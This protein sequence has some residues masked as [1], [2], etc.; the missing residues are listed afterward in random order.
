MVQ[1][2]GLIGFVWGLG[3]PDERKIGFVLGLIGFVFIVIVHSYLFVV[4]CFN[5]SCV[6][7]LTRKIGFVLHENAYLASRIWYLAY[8]MSHCV[9]G[10]LFGDRKVL[11]FPIWA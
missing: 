4:D 11:R 6:D 1:K 10:G 7:S 9:M 2:L 5:R 3:A 8:G